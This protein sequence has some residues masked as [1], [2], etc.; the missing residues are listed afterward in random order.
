MQREHNEG[1]KDELLGCTMTSHHDMDGLY[2]SQD[3]QRVQ[4]HP[5]RSFKRKR[6]GLMKTR[7][8]FPKHHI[9]YPSK[10]VHFQCTY[11]PLMTSSLYGWILYFKVKDPDPD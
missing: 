8:D 9:Q 5:I 3:F 10:F 2:T 4:D 7:E 1:Q 6:Y 11:W